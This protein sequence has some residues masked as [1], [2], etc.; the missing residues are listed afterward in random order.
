MTAAIVKNHTLKEKSAEVTSMELDHTLN[1]YQRMLMAQ[2]MIKT[3]NKNLEVDAGQR[4]YK[5]VNERDVLDAVKKAEE[6]CGIYSYPHDR[7]IYEQKETKNS[8]GTINFWMRFEVIY[9]FVNVDDPKDFI[10]IT[11]YGDGVDTLDKAPGKGM[12]Y[13]D[14][15]ALMK[16]YKISTGDDPDK[17][18]STDQ[19]EVNKE[20]KE[21]IGKLLTLWTSVKN[22]LAGHKLDVH[23]ENITKWILEK[24]GLKDI[25]PD[26]ENPEKMMLLIKAGNTLL[27]NK[28]KASESHEEPKEN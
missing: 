13:A 4:K 12:T 28:K 7:A 8:Y 24:T 5:A 20:P 3:V 19:F 27:E 14:K 18:G 1:I 16:A 2:S 22:E 23:S 25:N 26:I 17:E 11:T 21:D 6:K 10:D 15:Y 9:R